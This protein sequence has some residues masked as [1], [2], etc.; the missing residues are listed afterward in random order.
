MKSEDQNVLKRSKVPLR[1]KI[2]IFSLLC[3]FSC[4]IISFTPIKIQS[5][6]KSGM[7]I[8]Y[9]VD[10][11]NPPDAAINITATYTNFTSPLKLEVGWYNWPD[12]TLEV[13]KDLQFFSAD[14]TPIPWKK[15]DYRTIGVNTT[16]SSIVAK[17]SIDL[18]NAPSYHHAAIKLA[19]IGGVI[20]GNAAFLVPGY[21]KVND[22]KV[23]FTVPEPWK[24]VSTYPKEDGWFLIKPYTVQDLARETR[25]SG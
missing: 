21:Q 24:V 9:E 1:Q 17:Y 3:V 4:T 19:S 16:I 12:P 6:T 25:V 5:I 23:K 11:K 8:T 18:R 22:V 13:I 10:I 2:I 14:G 7:D 15:I 20:S